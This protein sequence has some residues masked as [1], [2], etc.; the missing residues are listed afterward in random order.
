MKLNKIFAI[1]LAALTLT[2]C[3][4]D[5]DHNF[6]GGL[7]T[8][9]GVTVEMGNSSFEV[10]EN[11]EAFYVPIAVNGETNGKVTVTVEV[12]EAVLG[13]DQ[14]A[15]VENTHYVVTSKTVNIAAGETTGL[16]EVF[17]NWESG[18]INNDRLFDITIVKVEGASLGAQAT[19]TVN[20]K[21]VD[22]AYTMMA[23]PWTLTCVDPT[24]GAEQSW[25]VDL[26]CLPADDPYYGTELDAFGLK[27]LDYI[28]LPFS[29]DYDVET[30]TITMEVM[31][32]AFCTTS[33]INFTGLGQ[34]VVVGSSVGTAGFGAN[35]PCQATFNSIEVNPESV[36][37]LNVM[38]YPALD[39]IYG[40]WGKFTNIKLTR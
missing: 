5:D 9:S 23:G 1:A 38:P 10:P 15:A 12:R 4:D 32:G 25:T 28:Y 29:F 2:A 36:F 40:H 27:G 19:C 21:N 8:V 39:E 17:N 18:V 26:E 20:I 24:T 30:E 3:S 35:I 7:N 22:D 31:T 14:E 37:T 11:Q 6:L 33:I 34:C 16:L 13:E